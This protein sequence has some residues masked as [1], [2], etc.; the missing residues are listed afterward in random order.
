[1]INW[2]TFEGFSDYESSVKEMETLV[3][4]IIADK[5]SEQIWLLQYNS[6]YTAGTSAKEKDLI[7]RAVFPIHRARR[8]GQFTYHGP[9][10]RIIYPILDLRKL[11]KDVRYYIWL[12]EEW[13][14][15]TISKFKIEGQ[16]HKGRVGI[17]VDG[18]NGEKKIAAI[19]VRITKWIS[20][21]GISVNL[22]PNLSNYRG[23]VPCGISDQGV[24]SFTDL[25]ISITAN[26]FDHELK[27]TFQEIFRK[28]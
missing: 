1:M 10:Q 13:I 20:S 6:L 23:I 25:G 16:R 3:R 7:E 12:L 22:D 28:L 19:G 9:G 18:L 26:E 27:K 4:E 11:R 5:R 15:K 14:I 8:G 24:T 2:K 21:H 17:W